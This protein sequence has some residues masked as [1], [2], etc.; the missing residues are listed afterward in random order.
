[1]D[2]ARTR[3]T[4]LAFHKQV[5][6]CYPLLRLLL[7][8]LNDFT[9]Q[10]ISK[11]RAV[12]GCNLTGVSPRHGSHAALLIACDALN[13]RTVT[14]REYQYISLCVLARKLPRLHYG[15][16]FV[17]RSHWGSHGA[18]AARLG[19]NRKYPIC[20]ILRRR[21]LPSLSLSKSSFQIFAAACGK[22]N[23]SGQFVKS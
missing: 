10:I 6:L 11:Y 16:V 12:V 14:V 17:A 7:N 13:A 19:T 15:A 8:N 22:R 23:A 5:I 3:R 21:Y 4:A 18:P 2:F 20:F 9:I 1:M